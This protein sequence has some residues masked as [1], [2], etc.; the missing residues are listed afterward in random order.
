MR[1]AE[2]APASGDAANN[3]SIGGG[4]KKTFSLLAALVLTF[5]GGAA[6]ALAQ[7]A[8][9]KAHVPFDFTV[10]GSTLSAGDYTFAKINANAWTIRNDNTGKAIAALATAYGTNQ[11]DN[12]GAV[13]F[14]Q[15]GSSYFLSEVR[16]LGETSEVPA[17]KAERSLERETARN[18]SK[19]QSVYVLASAR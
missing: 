18:G 1:G 4:M 2:N 7:D 11:D 15:F 13:V 9:V 3:Q 16:C 8:I 17:S 12:L 14:K 5:V 10:S 19:S 6:S